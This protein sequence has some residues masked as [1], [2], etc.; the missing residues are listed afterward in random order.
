VTLSM[1]VASVGQAVLYESSLYNSHRPF[2]DYP[3]W[4]TVHG[5][6]IAWIWLVMIMFLPL[7][8]NLLPDPKSTLQTGEL[9]TG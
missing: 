8:L 6:V 9:V 7:A 5:T 4:A 3:W 1:F 2:P